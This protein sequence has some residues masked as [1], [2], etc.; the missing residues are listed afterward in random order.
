[1][2]FIPSDAKDKTLMFDKDQRLILYAQEYDGGADEYLSQVIETFGKAPEDQIWT[3]EQRGSNTTTSATVARYAFPGTVVMVQFVKTRS[4]VQGRARTTEKTWIG[5]ADRVWVER[6][7]LANIAEKRKCLAWVKELA[8]RCAGGEIDPARLPALPAARR[9]DGLPGRA[10]GV[11]FHDEAA[12]RENASPQRGDAPSIPTLTASVG[13]S[14]NP[15]DVTDPKG[16]VLRIGFDFHRYRPNA[17]EQ[18]HQQDW[19]PVGNWVAY[20]NNALAYTGFSDLIREVN[21]ALV[22]EYFPPLD[23]VTSTTPGNGRRS[24]EWRTA[25]GWKVR[26]MSGDGITL[27]WVGKKRL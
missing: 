12:E 27:E 3:V 13:K 7:L 5:L 11:E 21:A 22:Q 15:V 17:T 14:L 9:K 2:R 23:E 4:V 20:S 24:R 6:L 26:V 18:L 19:L 16:D 25:D 10:F 1:M 8:E